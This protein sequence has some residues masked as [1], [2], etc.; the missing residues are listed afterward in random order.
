MTGYV[1]AI[2]DGRG[3]VK[4]GWSA[5]PWRRLAKIASDCPSTPSLLGVVV[6]TRGQEAELHRL[7][8][9]WQVTREWFSLEGPVAHF[10]ALL[11]PFESERKR[12]PNNH[13]LA[14][15][16]RKQRISCEAFANSIGLDRI[17][18]WRWENGKRK[19]SPSQV[20]KLSKVTGIPVREL[21][22]DLAA[23]LEH[24]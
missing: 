11:R 15:Y 23:L 18:V 4:V 12:V 20:E 22:P 24:A 2:S 6:A 14:I 13:P 1:Y 17:T 8:R 10:V 16:R 19:P 3:R 21:R 7:L 9:P 5:Q